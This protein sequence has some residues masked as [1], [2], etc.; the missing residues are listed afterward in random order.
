M[1]I[2]DP[3]NYYEIIDLLRIFTF[4]YVNIKTYNILK[5][6]MNEKPSHKAI[7]FLNAFLS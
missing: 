3:N 1:N 6:Q 4:F 5:Y 7:T 2:L